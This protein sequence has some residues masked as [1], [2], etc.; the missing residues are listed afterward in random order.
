MVYLLRKVVAIGLYV[1]FLSMGTTVVTLIFS[2]SS[3]AAGLGLLA[4]MFVIAP[5]V[6]HCIN[7]SIF[8][9]RGLPSPASRDVDVD[10]A[11]RARRNAECDIA[12]QQYMN[13][14]K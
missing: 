6:V 12:I 2:D 3:V 7:K 11:A 10:W 4:Y 8:G 14:R 9:E 13:H 1:L 5:I